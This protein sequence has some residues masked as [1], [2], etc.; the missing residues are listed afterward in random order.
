MI[1]FSFFVSYRLY[2]VVVAVVLK[3]TAV[4]T[5]NDEIRGCIQFF[6]LEQRLF[7]QFPQTPYKGFFWLPF[8]TAFQRFLGISRL[9][10]LFS[11][12]FIV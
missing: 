2:Y 12:I 11:N 4:I 3:G 1:C 8:E 7:P 10:L 5:Q 6:I 9:T